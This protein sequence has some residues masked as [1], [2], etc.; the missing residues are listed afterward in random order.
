MPTNINVRIKYD[1]NDVQTYKGFMTDLREFL[2]AKK[3]FGIIKEFKIRETH[4]EY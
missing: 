1:P 4:P 2:E 3:M